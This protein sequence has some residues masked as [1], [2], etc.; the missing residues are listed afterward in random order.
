M[1]WSKASLIA[2]VW[3]IVLT[4][5]S[6]YLYYNDE[7]NASWHYHGRL[8]GWTAMAFIGAALLTGLLHRSARVG[9]MVAVFGSLGWFVGLVYQSWAYV[10]IGGGP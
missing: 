4:G 10:N 6:I 5:S 1:E 7:T 3:V 2:A 9:C 8:V